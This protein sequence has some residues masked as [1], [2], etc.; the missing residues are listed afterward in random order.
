MSDAAD[1]SLDVEWCPGRRTIAHGV[2][3]GTCLNNSTSSVNY[4]HGA[5]DTFM[6]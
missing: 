1:G 6:K 3:F 5:V 4:G 2:C